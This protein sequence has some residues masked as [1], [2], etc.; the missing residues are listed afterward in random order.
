MNELS[1]AAMRPVRM[2]RA[3]S[4]SGCKFGVKADVGPNFLCHRNPPGV[5]FVSGPN[6][7]TAIAAFPPVRPDHWCG[8]FTVRLEMN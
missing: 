5:A 7:P 2:V 6:G 3:Q 4:C 1:I 8:E